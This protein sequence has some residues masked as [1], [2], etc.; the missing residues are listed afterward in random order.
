MPVQ[1]SNSGADRL[2]L[3]P[4][5]Y[6]D[7]ELVDML[8]VERLAVTQRLCAVKREIR[9]RQAEAEALE[10]RL[11]HIGESEDYL[12]EKRDGRC[13]HEIPSRPTHLHTVK[14]AR[15]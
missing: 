14:G 12:A 4:S 7:R 13:G 15:R 2:R 6:S 10:R 1:Q 3:H 9:D 8:R 11:R 5:Q